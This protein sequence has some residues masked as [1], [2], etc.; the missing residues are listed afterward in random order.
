MHRQRAGNP[1]LRAPCSTLKKTNDMEQQEL[2][3]EEWYDITIDILRKEYKYSGP[4]NADFART[5]LYE[6]GLSPE[7][8]ASEFIIAG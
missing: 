5:D 6:E 3:F 7:A 8:A 4:F 2:Q 1:M